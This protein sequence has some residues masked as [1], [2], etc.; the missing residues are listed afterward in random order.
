[1]TNAEIKQALTVISLEF[2]ERGA[3]R[4]SDVVDEAFKRHSTLFEA[5]AEDLARRSSRRL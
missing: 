4:I 1:M 2:L 3:T 5:Y